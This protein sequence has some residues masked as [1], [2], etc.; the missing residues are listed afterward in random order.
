MDPDN[1]PD[2]VAAIRPQDDLWGHVNG[3]WVE[4]TEIPADR[5]R[6]G[7][8]DIMRD[9]VQQRVRA[10]LDEAS[11]TPGSIA[12][13]RVGALHASFLDEQQVQSRGVTALAEDLDQVRRVHDGPSLVRTVA[14]LQ[15]TGVPGFLDFYVA[16][17]NH[18]PERCGLRFTQAGLTLPDESFHSDERHAALRSSYAD[19]VTRMFTL[20]GTADPT[21]HAAA[22][23]DLET[24]IAGH[25]WDRVRARD[26][27]LADNHFDPAGLA[28]LADLPWPEF[29]EGLGIE[30]MRVQVRQ[31]DFLAGLGALLVERPLDQWR[32]WLT[33][34]V[35]QARAELLPA[36]L[37]EE[38]FAFS[39]TVLTGQPEQPPRWKRA[40]TLV[41]G[42]LGEEL[43]GLYRDR[44]LAPDALVAMG[45]LVD[46]FRQAF[47]EA[48]GQASWMASETSAAALRKLDALVVKVG[49]PEHPRDLTALVLDRAD[50]VGNV[51][52][53]SAF[54]HDHEMA[55]LTRPVDADHWI[56]PAHVVN[57]FY[58]PLRNEVYFPAGILQPPYLDPGADDAAN[59]GAIGEILG[60]EMGHAFD[61]QGSGR[62]ERGA[63]RNWWTEADRV[64]FHERADRLVE[65]YAVLS[66]RQLG[67]DLTVDGRLTLG[68]NIGDLIGIDIAYR[69]WVAA[70][71]DGTGRTPTIEEEQ[72]F[73]VAQ[74]LRWRG[75][76]R[77]AT[78]IRRLTTDP[79]PPVEFRGNIVRNLDAFHDAFGVR[80]GDGMWLDPQ[81]RVRIF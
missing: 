59:F 18:D 34:R 22:V 37:V 79:H 4:Q 5:S 69:A 7:L 54:N 35:L 75:M 12:A 6:Y 30:P 71:V 21:A 68:E 1:Q 13:Q 33:W 45:A 27:R 29:F 8:T 40:I 11:T 65:Q 61:D 55:R 26:D 57:A 66:P 74:A 14:R 28:A 64:A 50:L 41:D 10:I 24:R 31:P 60:H 53:A 73:F 78:A 62:D 80:P 72:A 49:G 38:H 52:R 77:E 43:G 19:H 16:P 39:G 67:P 63:L 56:V 23:L 51:R 70:H 47:A 15:R 20:L 36:A 3:R 42:L 25:H 32:S 9:R 46:A 81:D 44:H 2:L 17:D 48:L 76:D 58:M